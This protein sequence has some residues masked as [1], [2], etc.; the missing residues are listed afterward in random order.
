MLKK[1][2]T[3]ILFGLLLL[4]LFIWF[5]T[6]HQPNISHLRQRVELLLYDFRLSATLPK[7]AKKDKRVVIVDVD[8]ASLRSE[9]RWP[10]PRDRLAQL[11]SNL[12]DAGA[13]VVAYDV[14]FSERERNSAREVHQESSTLLSTSARWR[15]FLRHLI[16]TEYFLKH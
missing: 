1:K 8:E 13:I 15:I 14:M 7:K 4:V 11:T 10:W 2:L 6:S 12:F 3:P 9:G 16:M 5:Q